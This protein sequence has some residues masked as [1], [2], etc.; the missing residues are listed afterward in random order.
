MMGQGRPAA[1]GEQPEAVVEA[2]D[3]LLDRQ[4]ARPGG[5]QLQRQRQA[6]EAMAEL[7]DQRRRR[8]RQ[9]DARLR[10]RPLDEELDSLRR[11]DRLDRRRSIRRREAERRHM[12]HRLASDPQRRPAGGG[13]C[14]Q[15]AT[16]RP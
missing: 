10:R 3:D 14:A 9:L 11:A 8:R 16:P 13:P 7:G 1:A 4:D 12:A 15:A 6:V 5:G 2:L